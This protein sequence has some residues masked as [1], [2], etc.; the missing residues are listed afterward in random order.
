[1]I[2][3]FALSVGSDAELHNTFNLSSSAVCRA[4]CSLS[5]NLRA[6]LSAVQV[7][8]NNDVQVSFKQISATVT[9][10][11]HGSQGVWVSEKS[12]HIFVLWS[13]ITCNLVKRGGGSRSYKRSCLWVKRRNLL[14]ISWFGGLEISDW[15]NPGIA[16]DLIGWAYGKSGLAIRAVLRKCWCDLACSKKLCSSAFAMFKCSSTDVF[17]CALQIK[18]AFLSLPN[19]KTRR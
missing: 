8:S 19:R 6:A 18:K 3:I 15:F 11:W 4:S 7:S 14:S 9:Y 2:W 12:T 17:Y 13:N 1:M 5:L 16:T 10:L